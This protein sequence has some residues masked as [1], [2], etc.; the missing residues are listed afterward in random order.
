MNFG[1]RSRRQSAWQLETLR[2]V[3]WNGEQTYL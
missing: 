1:V 2:T 3:S